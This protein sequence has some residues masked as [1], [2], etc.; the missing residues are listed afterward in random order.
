MGR[1]RDGLVAFCD[2]LDEFLNS[3][4]LTS[5]EFTDTYDIFDWMLPEDTAIAL[6]K[7]LGAPLPQ[8][9]DI[10]EGLSDKEYAKI[11]YDAAEQLLNS[12]EYHFDD[13]DDYWDRD[14]IED[15]HVDLY[16]EYAQH[17]MDM[18]KEIMG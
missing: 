8:V 2:M 15:Y 7:Q 9:P 11:I 6:H 1:Y 14:L 18:M 16:K 4:Y 3:V 10:I 13:D 17:V 12:L 5:E